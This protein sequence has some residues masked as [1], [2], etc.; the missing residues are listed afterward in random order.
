MLRI[1]MFVLA[2]IIGTQAYANREYIAD[3]VLQVR[4]EVDR[5]KFDPTEINVILGTNKKYAYWDIYGDY[6]SKAKI[7]MRRMKFIIDCH[8]ENFPDTDKPRVSLNTVAL[9]TVDNHMI[10]IILIPPGA[11]E[12]MWWDEVSFITQEHIGKICNGKK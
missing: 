6:P 11:E 5:L 4:P 1:M 7:Y 12:W 8:P 9:G 10:K 2:T 3:P